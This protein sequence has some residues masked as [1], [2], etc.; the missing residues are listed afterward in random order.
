MQR[1]RWSLWGC[2]GEV[3]L[4]KGQKGLRVRDC[5][6]DACLQEPSAKMT[7]AGGRGS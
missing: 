4:W 6:G 1:S 5:R 2:L 7:K 3:K